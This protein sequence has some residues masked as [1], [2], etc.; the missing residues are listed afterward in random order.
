[1]IDDVL[2]KLEQFY[3]DELTVEEREEFCRWWDNLDAHTQ[4]EARRQRPTDAMVADIA[5]FDRWTA[6]R[7]TSEANEAMLHFRRQCTRLKE[8]IAGLEAANRMLIRELD[9]GFEK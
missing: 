7:L 3:P 4:Y 5:T 2:E 1:M 8:R 6:Y 9:R